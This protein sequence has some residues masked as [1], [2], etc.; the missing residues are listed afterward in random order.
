M[1]RKLCRAKESIPHIMINAQKNVQEEDEGRVKCTKNCA[2]TSIQSTTTY[3]A[4][5]FSLTQKGNFPMLV[6]T[7]ARSSQLRRSGLG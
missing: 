4:V 3:V 6:P 7:K 5:P 2:R 1:H